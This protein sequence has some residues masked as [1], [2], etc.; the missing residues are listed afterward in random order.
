MKAYENMLFTASCA[1]IIH[2]VSRSNIIQAAIKEDCL[3]QRMIHNLDNLYHSIGGNEEDLT[4]GAITAMYTMSEVIADSFINLYLT[5]GSTV[6]LSTLDNCSRAN[7]DKVLMIGTEPMLL[8]Y[9]GKHYYSLQNDIV[10]RRLK[11]L[12]ND[13]SL[14]PLLF[15]ALAYSKYAVISNSKFIYSTYLDKK[16]VESIKNYHKST[17]YSYDSVD[18]KNVSEAIF[19]LS[20]LFITMSALGNILVA[21]DIFRHS[22][23]KHN[24]IKHEAE[25]NILRCNVENIS[26]FTDKLHNCCSSMKKDIIFKRLYNSLLSNINKTTNCTVP[27]GEA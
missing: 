2:T 7:V 1:G 8:Q 14:E 12:Y 5:Y 27:E 10:F 6:A 13:D 15:T 23:D 11:E 21:A 22:S 16:L 3:D 25:D 18:L 17:F 26:G 9:F 24:D 20:K 19:M 4:D